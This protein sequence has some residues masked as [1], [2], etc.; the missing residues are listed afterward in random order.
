MKPLNSKDWVASVML[1]LF[2]ISVVMPFV[3]YFMGK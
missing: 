2:V 1:A 3:I